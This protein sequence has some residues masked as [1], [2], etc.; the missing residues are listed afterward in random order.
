MFRILISDKLEQAGLDRLTQAEDAM[1]EMKMGLS[2]DELIAI[3]PEYDALI[4]R[5]RTKVDAHLLAAAKNLKVIGRAGIGVDNIDIHV[6]TERGIIIM[7]T[8]LANSI[9]S[10][11]QT[12]AL[13]LAVSRHIV[14]AHASLKAGE[15]K[16]IQF[17]G[18][19]LYRKTLG[20]IGLGRTGRLVAKR[21]Q[22]FG[23]E[24]VA[25]DPF[26]SEEIGR[27]LN[28]ML[29]DLDELLAYS[30]YISMHT[31]LLP[32]TTK[33][34]NAETISQ[35][36]DGVILINRARGQL[37]DEA[38][39]VDGL[40]SGKI[41]AAGIDVFEIEP[42][43]NSPLIGLPNVVHTPHLGAY[44]IEAQRNVATQVV[45]Q[46]LD[47]L[48]G[49]DFRNAINMPFPAGPGFA[50]TRPYIVLGEKLGMLQ[51]HLA[52]G[53][54]R[55]VEIEVHGEKANDVIR[56]VAAGVLKGILQTAVSDSVNYINAPILAKENGISVSQMKG[57]GLVDYPNLVSCQVHWENGS[58]QIGGVLFGGNKPRIVQVDSYQL[59]IDPEGFILVMQNKDTPGIIGQAGTLLGAYEVN[60]GEWRMG[61]HAPGSDALSFINL[62]SKP[63]TAVI[64]ALERIPSMTNVK[65]I[66]L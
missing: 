62:D 13:M 40:K 57:S 20:I 19:Q 47:A 28:V 15:W 37:V 54:I 29:L 11:E 41:K 45:D 42:P 49:D 52:G 35:M 22:A 18:N 36:K 33:M 12:M 61:R 53:A 44:T 3:I 48:R 32:T 30:D 25:Y 55:K 56:P 46:V 27:E 31:A 64:D 58:R 23:M 7:N 5:S 38:A 39:L 34:I 60:I 9:A 66:C 59:E 21:A 24:V 51:A 63:P 16:R 6:A 50:E 17:T 1:F 65:L 14:Q 10:A 4:I 2:Q 8:P 26:I 43:E